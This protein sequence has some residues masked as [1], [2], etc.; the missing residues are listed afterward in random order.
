[1]YIYVYMYVCM[2]IC[3][4]IYI[5][6]HI[7]IHIMLKTNTA[8]V[9]QLARESSRE[10]AWG[11]TSSRGSGGDRGDGDHTNHPQPTP[12]TY[13]GLLSSLMCSCVMYLGTSKF[14]N[15]WRLGL[16][17]FAWSL[18]ESGSRG[19]AVTDKAQASPTCSIIISSIS[20]YL[21]YYYY[22]H[23]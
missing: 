9:S 7:Y 3:I 23:E 6:I 18:G 4:Y 17:W 13:E 5:Y 20:Y 15:V 14:E 11:C 16:G 19:G 8:V 21:D 10:D 12:K 22:Y 1:M 2:C